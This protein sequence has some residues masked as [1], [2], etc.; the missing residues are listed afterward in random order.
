MTKN[1]GFPRNIDKAGG[2][3]NYVRKVKGTKEDSQGAFDIRL[4]L[5]DEK[6]LQEQQKAEKQR[7]R[8]RRRIIEQQRKM[9]NLQRRWTEA[10]LAKAERLGKNADKAA[11][12]GDG[13]KPDASTIGW[14][15]NKLGS[16]FKW[17]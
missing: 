10:E 8:G 16:G 15:R 14:I 9:L 4:R 3:D 1:L 6:G 12:S 13:Q 17:Q 11:Q 7:E 2:L 5:G